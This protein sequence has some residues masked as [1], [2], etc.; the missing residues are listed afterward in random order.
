MPTSDRPVAEDRSNAQTARRAVEPRGQVRRDP[1]VDPESKDQG[2]PESGISPTASPQAVKTGKHGTVV[3]SPNGPGLSAQLGELSARLSRLEGALEQTLA[4]VE[5]LASARDHAAVEELKMQQVEQDSSFKLMESRLARLARSVSLLEELSRSDPTR[6]AGVQQGTPRADA[7]EPSRADRLPDR[8]TSSVARLPDKEPSRVAKLP[9]KEGSRAERLPDKEPS[10]TEKLPEV[11]VP[12]SSETAQ[13]KRKQLA[14]EKAAAI[15]NAFVPLDVPKKRRGGGGLLGF[16]MIRFILPMGAVGAVAHHE[17]HEIAQ[18]TEKLMNQPKE[19]GT[20]ASMATISAMM[21]TDFATEPVPPA[22]E[23]SAWL[24]SRSAGGANPD[25]DSWGT[26]YRLDES[27]VALRS[28]GPDKTFDTEDD[29][30]VP[31]QVQKLDSK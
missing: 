15:A 3:I 8:E 14:P 25:S 21:Q 28:A 18:V 26:A 17:R 19:M 13:T 10:R 30:V 1:R 5:E 24:R 31:V 2:V 11:E 12:P 22:S 16:L 7:K 29:L 27:P 4:R 23:F 6:A 20:K 9:D